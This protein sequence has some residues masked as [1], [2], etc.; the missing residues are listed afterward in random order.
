MAEYA[1]KFKDV[2][3]LTVNITSE[4]V[5][6]VGYAR[7][8]S[9]PETDPN[10]LSPMIESAQTE[11]YKS[12]RKGHRDPMAVVKGLSPDFQGI[13]NRWMQMGPMSGG[14]D[15]L[16]DQIGK[17]LS[18]ELGKDIS[19]T[20]PLATGFV[21]FDL[22]SPSRLIYPVYS[23]F[24]NKLPRVAGQGMARRAKLVTGVAGSQTGGASGNPVRLSIN[25]LPGGGATMPGTSWPMNLPGS[26][27][28]VAADLLVPYKFFGTTEPI[29]WLSQFSGQGFEDISALANLVLLQKFMLGEEYS[30]LGGMVNALTAPAAPTLV[31]RT[32]VAIAET[33]LPN[34]ALYVLVTA[35]NIYGNETAYVSGCVATT[36]PS[37][38]VVDVKITPSAA[39]VAYNVYVGTVNAR[40]SLFLYAQ[41]VGA[42]TVSVS[43][44]T[45]PSSTNPPITDTG[46][47]SATDYD[48]LIP[49]LASHTGGVYSAGAGYYQPSANSTA[50]IAVFN[51]ALEQMWKATKADPG[52]LVMEGGDI[53]R[54]SDDLRANASQNFR[55]F[56]AQSEFAGIM[57]GAAVS[58]FINPVTRKMIPIMVHPW[59]PQGTSLLMSYTLP[60]PW[61]NVPNVQEIV[62]VQDYLSI[63][64]PVVDV[65]FRYS[66]F[67]YGA[68][69]CYAPVYNGLIQGLQVS[70]VAPYS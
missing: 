1:S 45:L 42:T 60:F 20:S 36:T 63:A 18:A 14:M 35:L 69:V 38:Q 24:R 67:L 29:S 10:V 16:T 58:E 8:G 51:T 31:K 11:L 3:S 23:P 17:V 49:I 50:R 34:A 2:S 19:L 48:G 32:A 54:L 59:M 68:L 27:S 43:G 25:E 66:M 46:T 65:T 52:E 26:T 40:T 57:A 61:T 30:I 7:G 5:K 21:P 22:V 12:V 62:N 47:G 6:G 4:L 9:K 39:A 13:M 15:Q 44:A 64:W 53:G 70:D 55:M 28:N 56:I 33:D 41:G 37:S